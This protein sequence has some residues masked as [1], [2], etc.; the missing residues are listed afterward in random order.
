[1]M[2]V[3]MAAATHLGVVRAENQDCLLCHGWITG[4]SGAQYVEEVDLVPR[5]P[6]VGYAVVDGMGGHAGGAEAAAT[7]A[8][9]LARILPRAVDEAATTEA[10]ERASRMVSRVGIGLGMPD[11]GAA[12]AGIVIDHA[13]TR[14]FNVGDCR[15]YREV[16]GYLGQ[17][18]VDD[19][20]RHPV[21]PQRTYVSQSLGGRDE[22]TL[23]PHYLELPHQDGPVTYLVC[24]DGLHD[25]VDPD[26]I[27]T[28]L[29][30][31]N[32]PSAAVAALIA[33]ALE[34]GAPDNV[35]VIVLM[36]VADAP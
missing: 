28:S 4:D 6:A 21:Y 25:A 33:R 18:S 2:R 23:D 3:L 27:R 34:A 12:V 7:A 8:I 19:R 30:E 35:S 20:V 22:R 16:G 32:S 10:L 29:T 11:M 24:S 1:M 15:V 36:V 9:M 5:V 14:I 26:G 13:S 17:V 31:A